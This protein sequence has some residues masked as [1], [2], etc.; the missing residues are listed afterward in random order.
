[1]NIKTACRKTHA[2]YNAGFPAE[3][4]TV[5][6]TICLMESTA[7][8]FVCES[9]DLTLHANLFA[10]NIRIICTKPYNIM[11]HNTMEQHNNEPS[12]R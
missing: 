12:Q 4:N 11:E 10:R 5:I 1:M 7:V 2:A 8:L 3:I 6:I 9:L